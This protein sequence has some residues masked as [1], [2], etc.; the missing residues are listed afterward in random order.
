[1]AAATIQKKSYGYKAHTGTDATT[2]TTEK[3]RLRSIQILGT[4]GAETVT[5]TDTK[6]DQVYLNVA[7][8]ANAT[9]EVPF[10][11][12]PVDGLK[13]TLSAST[14]YAIFLVA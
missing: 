7:T 4:A 13:V 8:T 5:V 3:V 9:Y 2:V 1:M 6:G 12:V 10:Y 11:G 14:V